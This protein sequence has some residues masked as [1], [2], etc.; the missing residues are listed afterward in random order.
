MKTGL[1]GEPCLRHTLPLAHPISILLVDDQPRNVVAMQAALASI[2]CN[3]VTAH[4]GRD[5]LKCLL[6]QDF[7]AIVL[8][9]HMPGM[10]GFETA[11]LIRSRDRSRSTPIIFLTADDRVG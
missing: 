4:S 10:D 1:I 5:A 8:D 9:I 6:N 2:D 11:S 7:A 3:L